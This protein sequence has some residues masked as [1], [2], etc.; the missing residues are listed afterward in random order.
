MEWEV[1]KLVVKGEDETQAQKRLLWSIS[2]LCSDAGERTR[3]VLPSC[4][5]LKVHS[6]AHDTSLLRREVHF[7]TQN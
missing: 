6:S 2:L 4:Q 3:S 5:Q 7:R 1:V